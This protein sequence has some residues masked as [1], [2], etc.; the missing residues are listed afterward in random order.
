V[1]GDDGAGLIGQ[2][3]VGKTERLDARRDLG[4]CSSL[5]VRAFRT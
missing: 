4:N 3:R 1:A 5:W 2:D